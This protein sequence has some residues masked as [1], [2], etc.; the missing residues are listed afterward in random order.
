MGRNRKTSKTFK[1]MFSKMLKMAT[2]ALSAFAATEVAGSDCSACLSTSNAEACFASCYRTQLF[3]DFDINMPE[4]RGLRAMCMKNPRHPRCMRV[5]GASQNR[6]LMW[7][8]DDRDCFLTFCF[9]F[10]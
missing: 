8:K 9:T 6:N 5:M 7:S 3:A 2:V 10:Y 4:K 1:K